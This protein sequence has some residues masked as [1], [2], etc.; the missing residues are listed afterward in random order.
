MHIK[1]LSTIRYPLFILMVM[2]LVSCGYKPSSHLIKEVFDDTVYV[3]VI[4]DKVEPENA[5][6]VKDE[7]NRLV[8]TRF[9]GRIVPKK[10]AKSRITVTYSGSTFTPLTYKNGYVVRYR[11]NV[12]VRF[13]MRT[14]KGKLRKRISSVVESDIEASSIN[15]SK[16]RTEAIRKGLEKALDQFLAYVAA[17]GMTKTSDKNATKVMIKKNESNASKATTK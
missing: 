6:Y 12:R 9:K 15:S 7:M 4:V 2:L 14:K 5:S 1:K 13:T 16:L 8:Y 10:Q 17:K 3:K 11:A